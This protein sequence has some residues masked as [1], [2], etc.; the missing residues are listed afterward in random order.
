M[1]QAWAHISAF[2]GAPTQHSPGEEGAGHQARGGGSAQDRRL[3]Q[4]AG[5]PATRCRPPRAPTQ[6]VDPAKQQRNGWRG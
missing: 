2:L 1:T 6:A 5:E 3:G 4:A